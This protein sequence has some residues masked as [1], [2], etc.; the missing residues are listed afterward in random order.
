MAEDSKARNSGKSLPRGLREVARS[1]TATRIPAAA[2]KQ[3]S[4]PRTARDVVTMLG[5]LGTG[6]VS[7][8]W[9]RAI[10]RTRANRR[11]KPNA[12]Q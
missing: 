9:A 10:S 2:F 7:S 4:R 11:R 1:P 5:D 8:S 12:R 3:L 6:G